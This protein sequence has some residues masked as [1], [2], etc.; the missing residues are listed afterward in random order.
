MTNELSPFFSPQ[1]VALIGASSNPNKIGYGVLRNLTQYGY[2]GYVYPVNPHYQEVTGLP[3][4]PDI[5]DVP[6]PIDLAVIILPARLTPAVLD[7]CGK[8][9][10]KAA[11]IISGGFK[12]VGP[13]GAAIEDECV[14]I[15]RR[16]G[17][18]LM[19]PNCVGTID[20]NTGLNTTFIAGMP[21]PGRIGFLSQ[22]GGVCG[23]SIDYIIGRHI[24][25]SCR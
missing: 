7:A 18:R 6:D 19:G 24:G 4:Y 17:M 16:Y 25:F 15:A 8:R 1:G 21:N 12:E 22:S 14:D 13:E 5:V 10:I 2:R 23:G 11:I 3:C 9:G 20:L